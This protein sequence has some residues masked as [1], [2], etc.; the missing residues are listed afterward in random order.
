MQQQGSIV[1]QQNVTIKNKDQIE[2]LL[3]LRLHGGI[4]KYFAVRIFEGIALSRCHTDSVTAHCGLL[5]ASIWRRVTLSE[6]F[7]DF[8]HVAFYFRY[9]DSAGDEIS[10]VRVSALTSGACPGIRVLVPGTMH[11]P[12]NDSAQ[13]YHTVQREFARICTKMSNL[14]KA[15]VDPS[16]IA[17]PGP[18]SQLHLN[19]DAVTN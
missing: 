10:F 14:H 4:R 16:A 9:R 13:I 1:T 7:W 5:W 2:R 8:L 12:H 17:A 3:R 18:F 11:L 19:H 15:Q 6:F